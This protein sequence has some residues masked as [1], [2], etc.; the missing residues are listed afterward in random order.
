MM[1]TKRSRVQR[2]CDECRA[3]IYTGD[4]YAQ[5]SKRVGESGMRSYDGTVQIWEPY[6]A[7][8]PICGLCAGDLFE[9]R[10]NQGES[11]R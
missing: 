6:Y 7:K 5:R 2:T 9:W 3:P 1:K 4:Q 10:A 11:G 8:V